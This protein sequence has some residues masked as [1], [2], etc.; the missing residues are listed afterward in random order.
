MSVLLNTVLNNPVQRDRKNG[1]NIM[2]KGDKT[3]EVQIKET[4]Q[5][6]ITEYD[7]MHEDKINV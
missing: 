5:E 3:Q 6:L 7:K 1:T 2:R 4:L